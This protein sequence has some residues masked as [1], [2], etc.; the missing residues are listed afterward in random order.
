MTNNLKIIL[1]ATL[2]SM[3]VFVGPSMA[4][5]FMFYYVSHL[6]P[7]RQVLVGDR[8]LCED[9]K[10]QIKF[11][12]AE[13]KTEILTSLLRV[14]KL[15]SGEFRMAV[16]DHNTQRKMLNF[17]T[18][19]EIPSAGGALQSQSCLVGALQE[20][21]SSM[22]MIIPALLESD[23]L[24]TNTDSQMQ[25]AVQNLISQTCPNNTACIPPLKAYLIKTQDLRKNYTFVNLLARTG[26]GGIIAI[27]EMLDTISDEA[28]K[29]TSS[30][31]KEYFIQ[32]LNVG[33]FLDEVTKAKVQDE[34][35]K[36]IDDPVYSP[37]K[38]EL[39]RIFVPSR[40][41]QLQNPSVHQAIQMSE[42]LKT[43]QELLLKYQQALPKELS[44]FEAWSSSLS[45]LGNQEFSATDKQQMTVLADG[46]FQ[47]ILKNLGPNANSL[48][49]FQQT[50]T[51]SKMIQH[52]L[53]SVLIELKNPAHT[54]VAMKFLTFA[55]PESK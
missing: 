42:V 13:T 3:I 14:L 16:L 33:N 27:F 24:L 40:M 11:A 25:M 6:N 52:P 15:S 1:L 23:L 2:I 10:T 45:R 50:L 46:F 55:I 19:E 26:T 7:A 54:T 29:D 49:Q 43:G 35:V 37:V 9:L 12:S 32:A 36:R 38:K 28:L 22:D 8:T 5:N 47:W 41:A 20:F 17:V 44:E 31:Q 51:Y 30:N 4:K 34:A 21:P 18:S 48:V 53:P 39:F